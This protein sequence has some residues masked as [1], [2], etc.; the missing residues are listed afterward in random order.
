MHQC[1]SHIFSFQPCFDLSVLSDFPSAGFAP[2][3][4][5][6]SKYRSCT[7]NEDTGLGLAFTIA[8]ESGH[9]YVNS[10]FQ[11]THYFNLENNMLCNRQAFCLCLLVAVVIRGSLCFEILFFMTNVFRVLWSFALSQ[12][13]LQQNLSWR[14]IRLI[15][16]CGICYSQQFK[17][18]GQ[19][20]W[21][22]ASN[23]HSV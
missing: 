15:T 19:M 22:R 11:V 7:I 20:K 1:H 2:I 17:H 10:C 16:C 5:M 3:S 9:K 12:H 21:T 13:K 23:V 4:G 8:H 18:S 14:T 6:C